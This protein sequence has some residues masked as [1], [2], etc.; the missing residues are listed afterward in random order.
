MS[1]SSC[2]AVLDFI[3]A[4]SETENFVRVS[5]VLAR[6]SFPLPLSIGTL[7]FLSKTGLEKVGTCRFIAYDI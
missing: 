2:L 7:L 6:M 3:N 1:L 4:I 5:L